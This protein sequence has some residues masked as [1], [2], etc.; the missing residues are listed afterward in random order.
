[1][2][3]AR[4]SVVAVITVLLIAVIKPNKKEFAITLSII[5]GIFSFWF[6][7]SYLKTIIE[8]I[9]FVLE[10]INLDVTIFSI[11]IKIIFVAYI[12][13]FASNICRDAGEVS[14]ATKLELCGKIIIVYM[15]LPIVEA[16]INL[17]ISVL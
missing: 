5:F 12:C 7:F 16:V 9:N 1:M 3:I 14:I 8:T 17:L 11:I 13:E 4:I 6:V 15:S 10:K 2:D